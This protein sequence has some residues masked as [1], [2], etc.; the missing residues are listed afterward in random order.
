MTTKGTSTSRRKYGRSCWIFEHSHEA[1]MQHDE[2]NTQSLCVISHQKDLR[3]KREIKVS[4]EP[5]PEER[6]VQ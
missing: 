1:T 5:N 3:T 4:D 6:A 2:E